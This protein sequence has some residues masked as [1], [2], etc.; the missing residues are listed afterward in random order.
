MYSLDY[1]VANK[2]N[3][4]VFYRYTIKGI[5]MC[6]HEMMTTLHYNHL[7]RY[8]DGIRIISIKHIN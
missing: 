8:Q 5:I 1:A 2:L 3:L 4:V 6:S 7:F